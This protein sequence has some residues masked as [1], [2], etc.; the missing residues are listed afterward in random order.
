MSRLNDTETFSDKGPECP[1][2]GDTI[3]P[4]EGIYY[5]ETRY[6]TDECPTCEKKFKVEVHT[7]TTWTCEAVPQPDT[8]R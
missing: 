4:D 6:V 5:D 3:M 8:P 1:Y 7:S 2:C